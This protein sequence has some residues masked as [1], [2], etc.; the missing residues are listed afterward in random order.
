[1]TNKIAWIIF[2]AIT[3]F[4]FIFLQ[5]FVRIK[6]AGDMVEYYGITETLINHLGLDLTDVDKKSLE[7]QLNPGQFNDPNYY[8]EGIDGKKYPGHF[9]LYSILA[10]PVRV[11]LK[12]LNLDQLK[13][14]VFTNLIIL[15]FTVFYIL[16]NFLKSGFK[17]IVFLS[18]IYLSPLIS[19]IIWPG[20]DLFYVCF[21]MLSV[22]LFFKKSYFSASFLSAIASWHSQPLIVISLF[23]LL[24]HIAVN[25]IT[26]DTEK[27][28][29]KFMQKVFFQCL[30]I[31]IMLSV[32]YIYNLAVIGVLTPWTI[33]HEGWTTV[34]GFGLHN[35]SLKKLFE[36]FFDLNM[37]LFFYAPLILLAGIYFM[38]KSVIF[39]KKIYLLLVVLIATAFMYQTNP[40]WHFGTAGYGP[41]RHILF[42]MPFL[43]Y[44]LLEYFQK[45]KKQNI[46]L[47]AIIISQIFVLGV[48]GFIYPDFENSLKNTPYAK[49]VLEKFPSLYNPTPEIFVDRTNHTDLKIPSTAMY[50]IGNKCIKAYVL[51]HD[52]ENVS[53]ECG[54]I[55]EKYLAKLYNPYLKKTSTSRQVW[56]IEAT[57][58]PDSE[59]CEERFTQSVNKPYICLKTIDEVIK[60]TGIIDRG[61]I[62]LVENYLYP[63]IWR[64]RRGVPVLISIPA[65]YIVNHYSFEGVYVDF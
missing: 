3:V 49:F 10:T 14:L 5:F 35:L 38:F 59:S 11:V 44:F 64:M 60:Y 45:G 19:F 22:F 53:K 62:G 32:P 63:G 65:G 57:F 47:G 28:Y 54:W 37:G 40:S 36:Q 18:L 56:T 15:T 8:I 43:I 48:N 42:V 24:Y 20:P 26:S 61:R 29:F 30:L 12:T 2:G 9:I 41:T 4:L 52:V 17:R 13:T 1:M 31:L 21:L 34:Y 55:P 27:K 51:V 6:P 23:Y 33:F 39:D 7:R 58:W 46:I 50:K 16:K 25:F